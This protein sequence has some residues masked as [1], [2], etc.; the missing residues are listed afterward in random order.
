[1]KQNVL[2][3]AFDF[4]LF[5]SL[6]IACCTV[7]MV[8]Q[9]YYL[10]H[11]K[12]L[13]SYVG[14]VFFGSLCSYN[15]HMYLTPEIYAGSYKTLW[16]VKNKKLHLALYI[17]GLL[18]SAYYVWHLLHFWK[19]L[20]ATAFITFLYSAPKV[21][22]KP[23][24]QL[25][26]IAVGKTIFLTL[27]WA[28]STVILPL[29]LTDVPWQADEVLFFINRFTLIY[30]ICIVFDYRDRIEDRKEGIKSL[31]TTLSDKGIDILFRS[32][33]FIFLIT[34]VVLYLHG[35]LLI[36]CIALTVPGVIVGS[37]YNYSKK[38]A[39]DYLYL[40]ILDGLMMFSA[41]LLFIFHF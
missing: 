39:S 3:K 41:L 12:P 13:L 17:I 6:Y 24:Q 9:T 28:H 7:A 22:F 31:V 32:T 20:A 27:V 35:F 37:L 2:K 5:S 14:F 1:L 30:A 21:P 40:F 4:F 25:K 29:V 16:S 34:N 23:L 15:F 11:L 18:C 38:N 8:Y 10:F 26:H 36:D 19:W 33:L